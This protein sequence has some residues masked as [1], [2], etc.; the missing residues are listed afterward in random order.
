MNKK[1]LAAT[2]VFAL[3]SSLMGGMQAVE[4]A[5]A[6]FFVGPLVGISSP[7]SGKVY[8]NTS[9]PLNVLAIVRNGTSE[10]VRFL[11]SV[12]G[13]SNVT[14]T[15]L[16][17]ERTVGG[18]EFHAASFLENLAEGNHTLKVYSQDFSGKEMSDSVEFMID[19]N[20]KSPLLVL[21]PQ[22]I[23]YT[24]NEVAL[25]FVCSE[26]IRSGECRLDDEVVP[27]RGLGEG[28]IAKNLTLS[29]LSIGV[30][31]IRVVVWTTKG[32]FSQTI[33]FRMAEPEPFPTTLVIGSVIAVAVVGLGL[34]VYF[35]KRKHKATSN[36]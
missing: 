22:N 16:S 12:D 9:V 35:K 34:F 30:H 24:A 33:Y 21:S 25:T 6:N 27:P 26:E 8:T 14:L 5:A 17:K 20:F 11:Y 36:V 32:A 10:I 2:L 4:L 23:T 3:L 18:Y 19:T 7:S 15:N 1:A 13:N 31:E 28:S 29:G